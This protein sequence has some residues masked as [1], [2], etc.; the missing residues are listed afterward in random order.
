MRF[1]FVLC[2]GLFCSCHLWAEP[3]LESERAATNSVSRS[4]ITSGINQRRQT[5][6]SSRSADD[7][8]GEPGR[9]PVGHTTVDLHAEQREAMS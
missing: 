1:L 3:N 5:H 9:C 6:P 8:A 7:Q 4:L 2:L